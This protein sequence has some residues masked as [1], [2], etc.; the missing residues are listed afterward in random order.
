[1]H[2]IHGICYTDPSSTLLGF[3]RISLSGIID[4]KAEYYNILTK[5]QSRKGI[6]QYFQIN[7]GDFRGKN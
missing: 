2:N 6:D 1:M 7:A 4:K 5:C 3:N